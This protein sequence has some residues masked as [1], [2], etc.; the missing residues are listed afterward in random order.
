M[1]EDFS[2]FFQGVKEVLKAKERLGGI[3]G[4][5]AELIQTDQQHE[6]AIEIALG[7]ATQH[8]VTENEAAARQAIAYLKQHSFGR[9]T[10]LPMNVIKERTIQH[11]DVQQPSSTLHLSV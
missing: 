6:T 1:Q 4:A 8:V 2:G 3:H 7:A 5:I 9:A 10:F 11:R